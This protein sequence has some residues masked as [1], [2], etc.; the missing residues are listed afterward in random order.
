MRILITGLNGFAGRYL[1]E[2]LSSIS[3]I[4]IGG[5]IFARNFQEAKKSFPKNVSAFKCDLTDKKATGIVVKSFKPDA[6]FHLAGIA[7][8]GDSWDEAE[9]VLQTNIMSQLNILNALKEHSPKAKII[10][11]SSAQ[12]YGSV[13]KKELPTTEFTKLRPTNPYTVSKIT[14]ES[15]GYQY[16]NSFGIPAVIL[17]PS[18][19]IGPRQEA[20][21]AVA[22]F[23]KQIIDIEK[24]LQ[25]PVIKVGNLESLRDFTDV[26]DI[27]KAYYLA[28]LKCKPGE[29][30]NIG[31]GHAV[32]MKDILKKLLSLSKV[33]IKVKID[34][35][36]LR[37]SDVP[38]LEVDCS[39][40]KKKTGWKPEI[41]LDKTLKDTLDY[42]RKI[43]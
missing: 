29:I 38:V 27:V 22:H 28:I 16:F 10:I 36:L 24:G 20:F 14:Q 23:A 12:V 34:K 15:L 5:T 8:T 2:Y 43:E 9:K 4:K 26:R 35:N 1:E 30:Y 13:K 6:V 40:F 33:K 41:S 39:K 32:K 42:W 31:S 25:R 7:S 18:N 37:P 3:G 17:R 11:I 19:H 21:F